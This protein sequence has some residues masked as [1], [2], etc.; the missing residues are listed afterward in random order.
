MTEAM[1]F[2]RFSRFRDTANLDETDGRDMATL[3]ELRGRA[4]DETAAREE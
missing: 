4:E 1:E 2:G 3:L